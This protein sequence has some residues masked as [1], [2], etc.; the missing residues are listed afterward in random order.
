MSRKVKYNSV[1]MLLILALSFLCGLVGYLLRKYQNEEQKVVTKIEQITKL[2]NQF[3]I[4]NEKKLNQIIN[5]QQKQIDSLIRHPNITKEYISSGFSINGQS[6]T[7]KELI[8]YTNDLYREKQYYKN[9]YEI[10]QKKYNVSVK[11]S[12]NNIS[13]SFN[14]PERKELIADYNNL[15]KKNNTLTQEYNVVNKENR[16]NKQKVKELEIALKL[17]KNNYNID[18]KVEKENDSTN[19]ITVDKIKKRK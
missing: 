16:V 7:S 18:F 5:K 6:I 17:I 2:N 10:L 9:L 14:D 4:D 1:V 12:A 3:P 13:M 19:V 11:D 8:R 15:V